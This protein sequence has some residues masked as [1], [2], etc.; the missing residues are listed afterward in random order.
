MLVLLIACASGILNAQTYTISTIAGWSG[1]SYVARIPNGPGVVALDN[2]GNLYCAAMDGSL[3]K[4]TA[5]L[6]P[7]VVAKTNPASAIAVD[8]GGNVFLTDSTAVQVLRVTPAGA[9]QALPLPGLKSVSGLAL[10]VFG[11]IYVSDPAQNSIFR[12]SYGSASPVLI[13]GPLS[14]ISQPGALATDAIGTLYFVQFNSNVVRSIS[15]TGVVSTVA[16]SGIA[17]HSGDGAPA[18]NA[19][20]YPTSLASDFAGNLYFSEAPV[21]NDIRRVDRN[22][23]ITTIV[24]QPNGFM[25]VVADN[26]PALNQQ[27]QWPRGIALDRQGNV[28][29]A[30]SSGGR[31]YKIDTSGILHA[32]FGML[33]GAFWGDGGPATLAGL[34][35]PC[36]MAADRSGNLFFLDGRTRVRRIDPAGTITTVAS[37]LASPSSLALDP[38]GNLYV[39]TASGIQK[40]AADGSVWPAS[41]A[42]GLVAFDANGTAYLATSNTVSLLASDGSLQ[43]LAGTGV[44]GYSGDGGPASAATFNGINAIAADSSGNLFVSDSLNF[45]VRRIGSDGM[46]STFAG[47]PPPGS[48]NASYSG[49]P[50]TSV[51]MF[52]AGIA[53]DSSGNLFISSVTSLFEVTPGG[54]LT[55]IAGDGK[56]GYKGDNG[57]SIGA[58]FVSLGGLATDPAG[59]VYAADPQANSIRLLRT[60]AAEKANLAT[61]SAWEQGKC[62]RSPSAAQSSR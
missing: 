9:V 16:G 23:T 2:A 33:G 38:A 25:S 60:L 50:A 28:Y 42:A 61:P 18:L 36:C 51:Q 13:A 14:G 41:S 12:I 40:V 58:E 11:D 56:Q 19:R 45:R 27:I 48:V 39:A 8:L 17:G 20:I 53:V 52:P 43:P 55:R 31:V 29:F 62:C 6:T 54:L 47:G 59:D 30:D 57:L 10:D 44:T 35:V 37:S 22:G 4:L 15:T 21:Y 24:G 46:V 32:V 3:Y 49:V 1:N 26:V 5:G 7:S 34:T